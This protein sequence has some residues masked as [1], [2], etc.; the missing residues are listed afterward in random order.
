MRNLRFAGLALS[1]AAL[2]LSC[3]SPGLAQD[4]EQEAVAARERAVKALEEARA[5]EERAARARRKAL[6]KD[7]A[8]K[9]EALDAARLGG[10][11]A[12]VA[13][14][15]NEV[16]VLAAR[17]AALNAALSGGA[18]VPVQ[19][20]VP[21]VP[22]EGLPAAA[23][24]P[25]TEDGVPAALDWLARHQSPGGYWDSDGFSAPCTDG[26]CPGAGGP[27][28]DPGVTG[29]ATLAFLGSGETHKTPRHGNVVR[30]SLKYLKGIQD[31]EGCFGGRTSNH[32]VY[33][34]ALG[35]LA[36][37]ESFGLTQS[38]LF[39]SSAQNGVNFIL[40]ARNPYLAWRYGVKPGDNDTAVTGWMVMALRSAEVAGLD[41][42]REAYAG[43][44]AWLD[45][46]TEPEF[47]RAGY[48]AR[49][50]GPVRP[51][52]LMDAFP[53]DKSE[54]LTAQAV[55]ARLM[56]GQ[57]IDHD[58]VRKGL[59]LCDRLPPQWDRAAGTIDFVYW[60]FGTLAAQRAGGDQW[61]RWSDALTDSVA[62]YQRG[63]D[64][65]C[66]R[67]SWDP[68]DPWGAE[69]GRVYSTAINAMTME[70][71]HRY[72]RAFGGK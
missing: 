72:D 36:M 9:E 68:V 55:V 37:T 22:D 16:R 5:A 20:R 21:V 69:G 56:C 1:F 45:K 39:K 70:V 8:A 18:R 50:N 38:P 47:G 6:E 66:A 10:D 43:A 44:L 7:L 52:E 31:A 25:S 28:F 11:K 14:A 12:A 27:F 19:P 33:N 30:N 35:S 54:S 32:F 51:Q 3:G 64:S 13:T 53:S 34:H 42:D 63:E 60:Y 26:K 58:L 65:G 62:A 17:L 15:E 4:E 49:G 61:K 46:V 67:G 29:L 23:P 40:L 41:I 24:H 2:A 48:T 59:A 57:K 71:R